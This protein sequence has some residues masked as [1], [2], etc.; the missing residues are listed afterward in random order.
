MITYP[1]PAFL[2]KMFRCT[3]K[4]KHATVFFNE[5]F[6][7]DGLERLTLATQGDFIVQ[8]KALKSPRSVLLLSAK[9]GG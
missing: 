3:S 6:Q 5:K 7:F 1:T 8:T 2:P 4:R 9:F